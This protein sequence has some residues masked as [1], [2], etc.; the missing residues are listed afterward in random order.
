LWWWP[1]AQVSPYYA[2]SFF[3]WNGLP[4]DALHDNG[5]CHNDVSGTEMQGLQ[6]ES[7]DTMGVMQRLWWTEDPSTIYRGA[8]QLLRQTM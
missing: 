6:V 8:S 5:V 2:I 4:E 1:A 3:W 7:M